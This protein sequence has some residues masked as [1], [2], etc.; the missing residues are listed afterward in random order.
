MSLSLNAFLASDGANQMRLCTFDSSPANAFYWIG[1]RTFV[2]RYKVYYRLDDI[3]FD[4][5]REHGRQQ[6]AAWHNN[7]Y[8]NNVK[9]LKTLV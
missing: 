5:I 6:I 3:F 4:R 9:N 8:E 2:E 7:Q 1:T